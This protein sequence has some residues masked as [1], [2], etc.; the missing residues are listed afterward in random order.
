[1]E[2]KL[3]IEYIEIQFI[4]ACN[5]SCTGCATFSELKHHGYHKWDDTKKEILPWLKRLD[6]ECVGLMG[7]EPLMHPQIKEYIKGLRDLLPNSQIRVPTNG[8]LLKKHYD[9]VKLLHNIGNSVL[10]I[11]YHLNDK[12]IN[13]SIKEILNDFD[14]EPVTEYGINRW[15]T[16]N[17]FKFLINSPTM[18]L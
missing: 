2:N 17:N 10:K 5:L 1:M 6:P 7:G 12:T 4:H 3:H 13:Q 9:V 8:L 14:F 18:F 16:K 15:T 11:S